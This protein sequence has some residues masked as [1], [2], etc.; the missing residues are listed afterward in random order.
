MLAWAECSLWTTRERGR[1]KDAPLGRPCFSRLPGRPPECTANLMRRHGVP[2]PVTRSERPDGRSL[3]WRVS[4]EESLWKAWEKPRMMQTV[5]EGAW[6]CRLDSRSRGKPICPDAFQ[7]N[8]ISRVDETSCT[9][10]W[11]VGMRSGG[12]QA[13]YSAT[14]K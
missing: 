6:G 3:R 9:D 5:V 8:H 2:R 11:S 14:Q 10:R 4:Q 7:G 12:R 1:P 13:W